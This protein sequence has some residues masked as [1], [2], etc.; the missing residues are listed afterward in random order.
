LES[1]L[2]ARS[3][4]PCLAPTYNPTVFRRADAVSSDIS[5]FLS[6]STISP[7]EWQ[8]HP[9][10]S[11]DFLP[12]PWFLVRYISRLDT[13]SRSP[14][15][16]LLLAH[17]YVLYLGDLSGGQYIKRILSK[18]YGVDETFMTFYAFRKPGGEGGS[19]M[20][21]MGD[22]R[23]LKEWFKSGL[24]EGV[25]D[26]VVKKGELLKEAQ[27]AFR[28]NR[29]LL[30]SLVVD[31]KRNSSESARPS[32]PGSTITRRSS[33]SS[34]SSAAGFPFTYGTSTVIQVAGI[35]FTT[36]ILLAVI[37]IHHGFMGDYN[38]TR[39]LATPVH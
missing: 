1:A 2:D 20:A 10:Y 18:A 30:D 37:G 19:E 33:V 13:L 25:A 11:E 9:L 7:S 27:V 17:S 5:H 26:N 35:A 32:I 22:M 16:T 4:H 8:K 15:P 36:S 38:M 23:K 14:D 28:L 34:I 3:T 12:L 31:P 29:E 21:G 39:R 24:D 6:C